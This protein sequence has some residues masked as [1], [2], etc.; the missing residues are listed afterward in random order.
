[1]GI[2]AGLDEE[3]RVTRKLVIQIPCFNEEATLPAALADLPT[4]V[5]GFDV[6]EWLI[7][8]DGSTDATVATAAAHGVHHVVRLPENRG[9]ARAF[10]AGLNA[11]LERGAD[12][13]VNTDADNQYDATCI[14]DLVAPILA[15]NADIVIGARPIDYIDHFSPLKKLLQRLGSWVVRKASGTRVP[16]APSGFRAFSR[17]AAM[18]LQVFSAYTYTLE[19]IIQ[20]GHKGMFLASVPIR[21]NPK[22]RESRLVRSTSGYVG[23]SIA[24]IVRIFITY[25]PFKFFFYPGTVAVLAGVAI[26]ARFLAYFLAGHGEGKIQSLL[27]ASVL[28]LIGFFLWVIAFVADL[29]SVN[30]RLLEENNLRLRKIEEEIGSK[31]GNG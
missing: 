4:R 25:Q 27:L 16:D 5:E 6:V 22:T 21:T 3:L 10:M 1:M 8:D 7:V 14:P 12:V 20:A 30:R 29:I 23:R 26:G 13:I 9:L 11:C 2:S 24:T 28:V 17:E 18:Q 15:G 31:R 19:T